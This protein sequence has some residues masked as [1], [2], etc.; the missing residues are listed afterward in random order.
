M[1]PKKRNSHLKIARLSK[2]LKNENDQ[3]IFP[4]EES[5]DLEPEIDDDKTICESD[6][7]ESE[8]IYEYELS[9]FQLSDSDSD[10]DNW[11]SKTLNNTIE[12]LDISF[13]ENMVESSR[14]EVTSQPNRPL[15]YIGNSERTIRRR[16]SQNEVAAA[17]TMKLTSFFEKVES[18]KLM[19]NEDDESND[20][21]NSMVNLHETDNNF[22]EKDIENHKEAL[23]RLNSFL[24]NKNLPDV[25]KKRGLIISQYY[26]LRLTGKRKMEASLLLSKS[27]GCGEYRARLIR[28]WSNQFLK[29]GTIPV[30]NQGKHPKIKSLLWHEDINKKLQEYLMKQNCDI[31]VKSFK[32]FIESEIFPKIGIEE[33]KSISEKTAS[34]WLKELGW[35]YQRQHKDIYYDGHERDDVVKYR[36]IFLTQMEEFERLMPRPD[37]NDIMVIIEPSLNPGDKRYIIVTHDESVFYSN[38]GKKTFWGPKGHMPLRKKGTGLSIHVSDFLTE[39]DGRLRFENEEACVIM[40][41][42]VN[43]DGWWTSELLVDQVKI[44]K[45]N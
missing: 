20:I 29:F 22:D 27:L 8:N 33:K 12:E 24:K 21:I 39:I 18:N 26:N 17:N 36:E 10:D 5:F 43:R 6:H 3:N 45:V 1:P 44:F 11:H 19:V 23:K 16:K 25:Q 37:E 28:N 2:K 40:K 42:G 15:A 13:F 14:N 38:D 9:N 34:I 30:S 32:E 41:P 35:T 4:H 7:D 31:K